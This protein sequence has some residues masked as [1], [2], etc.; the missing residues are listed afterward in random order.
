RLHRDTGFVRRAGAGG[1]H[2]PVRC[3]RLDLRQGD[4]VVAMH[5]HL[6]TQLLQVL[7]DV[8]GKA[9]VIVDHQHPHHW[10]PPCCTPR[11]GRVSPRRAML[12]AVNTARPLF[13]VSFHSSRGTE[14][15]TTPAPTWIYSRPSRITAV[16]I[17]IAVS[18]SPLKPI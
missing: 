6:G 16:R 7:H 15:A 5:Q 14:S 3:Q 1:N 17:A 4:G 9:V 10:A 18:I 11:A 8:V 13:M 12:T 2:Q